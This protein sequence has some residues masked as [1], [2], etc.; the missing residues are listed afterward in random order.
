M[1]DPD[2]ASGSPVAR[3]LFGQGNIQAGQMPGS[4]HL[5]CLHVGP[6]GAAYAALTEWLPRGQ[7]RPAD[8]FYLNDAAGTPPEAPQ[9]RVAFPLE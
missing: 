5:V 3:A 2:V 8:E 7:R 4:Q 6:I 9:T 1:Q